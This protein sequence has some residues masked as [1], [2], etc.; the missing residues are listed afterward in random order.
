MRPDYPPEGGFM[1]IIQNMLPFPGVRYN[2]ILNPQGIRKSELSELSFRWIT[3]Y[4]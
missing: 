4:N 3:V 2:N 1:I